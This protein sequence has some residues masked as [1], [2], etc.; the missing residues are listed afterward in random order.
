VATGKNIATLNGEV[1]GVGVPEFGAILALSP[2]SK[3]LARAGFP[4]GLDGRTGIVQLWDVT[5]GKATVTLREHKSFAVCGA[6]SPDGKVLA[7]GGRNPPVVLWDVKAGKSRATLDGHPDQG[8]WAGAF[9]VVFS[10]AFS[11][12]GKVLAEA[13]LGGTI[14]LWDVVTGLQLAT[15]R[16]ESSFVLCLAFTP[17]GKTLATGGNEERRESSSAA[18]TTIGVLHLWDVPTGK[19]RATFRDIDNGI[20]AVAF[21]ADGTILLASGRKDG[22]VR[23]WDMA[24]VPRPKE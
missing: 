10:L 14:N 11:P 4:N 9:A 13:S 1:T 20:L 3:L 16:D 8:C 19:C 5:T 22:S 24:A 12:D 21:R 6:F 7:S 2:D 18:M 23:L 17:D 15:L